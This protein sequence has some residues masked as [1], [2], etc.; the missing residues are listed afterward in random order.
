MAKIVLSIYTRMLVLRFMMFKMFGRHLEFKL[1]VEV[2]VYVVMPHVIKHCFPTPISSAQL[3][4]LICDLVSSEL[5]EICKIIISFENAA[6]KRINSFSYCLHMIMGNTSMFISI[7]T[8]I[9]KIDSFY[10]T[11]M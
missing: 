1:I 10:V 5:F 4:F 11:R 2:V 3:V 8:S 7:S 9:R 6:R